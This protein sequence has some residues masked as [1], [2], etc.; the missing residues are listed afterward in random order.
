MWLN[1]HNGTDEGE[2]ELACSRL[3]IWHSLGKRLA[4]CTATGR[5]PACAKSSVMPGIHVSLL[6]LVLDEHMHEPEEQ[7]KTTVLR[8][9]PSAPSPLPSQHMGISPDLFFAAGA[10]WTGH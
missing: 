6:C 2:Q 7:V 9:S 5:Q 10:I 1:H 4:M 3:E 8:V